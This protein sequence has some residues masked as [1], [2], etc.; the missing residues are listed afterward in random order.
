MSLIKDTAHLFHEEPTLSALY[1]FTPE[2]VQNDAE[3]LAA[4]LAGWCRASKRG[5]GCAILS[6]KPL[7]RRQRL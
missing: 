6:A 1:G 4:V 3:L 7:N 5:I 2:E